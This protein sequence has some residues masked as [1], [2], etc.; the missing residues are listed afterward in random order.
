MPGLSTIKMFIWYCQ[1]SKKHKSKTNL[2]TMIEEWHL[3]VQID[4]VLVMTLLECC[5]F[6]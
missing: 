3:M 6:L 4:S 5:N 2:F 1:I